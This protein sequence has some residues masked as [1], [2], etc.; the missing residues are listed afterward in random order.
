MYICRDKNMQAIIVASVLNFCIVVV[1]AQSGANFLFPISDAGKQEILNAHTVARTAVS[2][3]DMS[4]LTWSDTLARIWPDNNP[5]FCVFNHFANR[6]KYYAKYVGENLFASSGNSS[7]TYMVNSWVSEKTDYSYGLYPQFCASGK[8]CGHYTQIIWAQ[9]TELGCAYFDCRNGRGAWPYIFVCNY[10][11]GGN[12]V[13][14][15]PYSQGPC[16]DTTTT[17]NSVACGSIVNR[18]GVRL[19]CNN[20]CSNLQQCQTNKCT[21]CPSQ[22]GSKTCGTVWNSCFNTGN[23]GDEQCGSN[24]GGCTGTDT[25]QNSQCVAAPTC[26]PTRN[27]SFCDGTVCGVYGNGC[28]SSI[29]CECENGLQCT[30]GKCQAP[31]CSSC[32]SSNF[33]V[34]QNNSCVCQPGYVRDTTTAACTEI[35]PTSPSVTTRGLSKWA[36]VIP[37]DIGENWVVL[38]DNAALE[39]VGPATTSVYKLRWESS[40]ALSNEEMTV[41]KSD[42]KLTADGI[43]SL[44]IREQSSG[45]AYSKWIFTV[46]G[47]VVKVT[48]EVAENRQLDQSKIAGG[49]YSGWKVGDWN[50]V[51]VG[52]EDIPDYDKF[53]ASDNTWFTVKIN[54]EAATQFPYNG[55]PV[56]SL[57]ET[58]SV[59]VE[60]KQPISFRETY[61]L[62]KTSLLVTFDGCLSQSDVDSLCAQFS[63]T[64][65]STESNC[66]HQRQTA[67]LSTVVLMTFSSSETVSS[68]TLASQFAQAASSHDSR[69]ADYPSVSNIESGQTVA[70]D[71]PMDPAQATVFTP[72]GAADGGVVDGAV[73]SDG[74]SGLSAGGIAGIAIGSSVAAVGLGAVAV[75]GA[76][77]V[78]VLIKRKK[79]ATAFSATNNGSNTKDNS[80]NLGP[81]LFDYD[82]SNKHTSIT[83]RAPGTE[84][85]SV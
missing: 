8:V 63:A 83:R 85:A 4:S 31:P 41:F 40:S 16:V 35:P 44:G 42:V 19:N 55:Y 18:C 68:E 29:N 73:V 58:G 37:S 6:T 71:V 54:G 62:T 78:G 32:Q 74:N 25:C 75:V 17:C 79:N 81:D 49:P 28:N 5:A 61:I 1:F 14:R 46:V 26:T 77:I 38:P 69:I 48:W 47:T 56:A 34:C 70:S 64:N 27:A 39:M 11:L 82:S 50:S 13:G 43:F 20:T 21:P 67:E 22:C 51:E 84:V 53:Y 2:A 45:T 10:A 15:Y 24:K 33:E 7:F 76:I 59:F 12:F 3:S 36:S 52:M 72:S 23:G 60:T 57:P 65:C 80:I 9:T 30:L 66:G